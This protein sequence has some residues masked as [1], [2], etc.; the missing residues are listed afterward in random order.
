[1]SACEHRA[2]VGLTCSVYIPTVYLQCVR[3][4]VAFT[5]SFSSVLYISLDSH[6][7]AFGPLPPNSES[8]FPPAV[9]K[10]RSAPV[11][12]VRIVHSGRKRRDGIPAQNPRKARGRGSLPLAEACFLPQQEGWERRGFRCAGME[13]GKGFI[14]PRERCLVPGNSDFVPRW[15]GR[16]VF[17]GICCPKSRSNR[18]GK[19]YET[20][21]AS[22]ELSWL[23]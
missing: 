22:H 3:A 16:S 7:S 9:P 2:A 4:S 12:S 20:G 19:R 6:R 15:D 14:R 10:H 13:A 18:Q 11:G 8:F 21:A 5:H 23:V 1:M 17:P